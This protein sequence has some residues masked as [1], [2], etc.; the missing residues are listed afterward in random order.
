MAY[1]LFNIFDVDPDVFKKPYCKSPGKLI[2]GIMN[3]ILNTLT[4]SFDFTFIAFQILMDSFAIYEAREEGKEN[5][6]STNQLIISSSIALLIFLMSNWH[7]GQAC[8]RS[9]ES[10]EEEHE[11]NERTGLLSGTSQDNIQYKSANKEE[12]PDVAI[13]V[14]QANAPTSA[15][16]NRCCFPFWKKSI[17]SSEPATANTDV[18]RQTKKRTV[19]LMV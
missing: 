18:E 19:T 3:L 17:A 4:Y 9:I 14:H 15:E 1:A 8:K 10:P 11:P 13:T 5:Y 2:Y 16:K 12:A 6:V 7:Y